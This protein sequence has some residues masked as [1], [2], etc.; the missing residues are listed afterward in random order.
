M[1]IYVLVLEDNTKNKDL[2]SRTE[3]KPNSFAIDIPLAG[4]ILGMF[5]NLNVSERLIY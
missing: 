1:A 5:L 3:S 2:L 4:F